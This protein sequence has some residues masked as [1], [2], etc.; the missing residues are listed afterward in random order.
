M[1]GNAKSEDEL[2]FLSV[3]NLNFIQNPHYI[4]NSIKQ[5]NSFGFRGKEVTLLP[6]AD[7][8][9]ILCMGGSTT[10]GYGVL[11]PDSS[12]PSLLEKMLRVKTG[13]NYRVIN[14]GLEGGTTFDEIQHYLYKL[15]YFKPNIV[16]I[17]S[18][19]N[20]AIS[21]AADSLES[22]YSPDF[23]DYRNIDMDIKIIAPFFKPFFSSRLLS[24]FYVY[25]TYGSFFH[26]EHQGVIVARKKTHHG[27]FIAI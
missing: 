21:C 20:D 24:A 15:R 5:N 1:L 17:H 25:S 4:N 7:E 11:E 10:Y 23:S 27:G 2:R 8:I 22:F 6:N 12:Y 19:G 16:V 9:R 18:G 14:A 3:A 26:V 13:K